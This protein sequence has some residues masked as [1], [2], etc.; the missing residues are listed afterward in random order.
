[1][2]LIRDKR[3]LDKNF[4]NQC[5]LKIQQALKLAQ[6]IENERFSNSVQEMVNKIWG[7]M[8]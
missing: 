2:K 8:N 3:K 7:N 1:M 4:I 5:A 6:N